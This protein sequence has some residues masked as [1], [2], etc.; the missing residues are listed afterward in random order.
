MLQLKNII[1][2]YVTGNETV[3]ALK[4]INI[5][6][7]KNEFVSILGQSGGGKTTLLN[8]IGGLDHYTKGDLIIGGKSTKEFSQRDWDSYRNHSIGF[9]FQSYNLI[10]HQSVLANVELALTLS[11]VGKAERKRRAK[12]ALEAVGLGA[13]IRKRPNQL[14]GGQMQRVAIARALVNDPEILLADEPT[15]ALD[16]ETSIQIMDILKEVAKDRLV[17]MVTHNPELATQYSTRIV[18]LKDGQIIDDNNP[19]DGVDEPEN[20]SKQKKTSMGFLTALSLSL[21]NLMT[22]RGRTILTAFA[23][24]IGI[25][26]IALILSLST[27][28]NNYITNI[29]KSTMSSYPITI[30]SQSIDMTSLFKDEHDVSETSSTH[31][32][33]AVYGNPSALQRLGAMTTS[34]TTNN[35]TAFKKY[36]DEKDSPILEYIGETGIH[37]SYD[38]SFDVYTYDSNKVLVNTDGSSFSNATMNATMMGNAMTMTASSSNGLFEE[39]LAGKG[40]SLVSDAIKE[41]YDL[42]Y[43]E[44]PS[45]YDEVVLVLNEN[46]EVST[47]D[48]YQLGYLPANEYESI[49]SQ[50][51]E[52]KEVTYDTQSIDYADICNQS[53]YM[54]P[55]SDY[56]VENT[57][58]TFDNVSAVKTSLE[59]L[60]TNALSLKIK[61]IIRLNEDADTALI[62]NTIGYTSALTDYIITQTNESAVVKAQ[63][64]QKDINVLTGISFTP[65]DENAKQQDTL[66]YLKN[67]G[68]SEKAAICKDILNTMYSSDPNTAKQIL[69][70]DEAT[71]AAS[72]D[73]YLQDPEAEVLDMIYDTYISAGSYDENMTTFGVVNLDTPS[74]IQIYADSFNDKDSITNCIKDYNKTVSED[75]QIQYTD[76]VALLMSS[77]TTIVN[78]ISY[79]L[80]AFVAV[81]L[82]VSSIM[83]GIITY[84]SVLERTKE[85]GILR[86]VG[87]SKKDISRVFNAETFIV[88]LFSGSLGVIITYLLCIPINS[89]IEKVVGDASMH[90][91]LPINSAFVLILISIILTLIAGL[92]PSRIAAKKDP[93]T[94]LRSE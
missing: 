44:W 6:F 15:G 51:Q 12:E 74:S 20:H 45:K 76:Y 82:V 89:V 16:T 43:G 8:I 58:G 69:S 65:T 83:I 38:V 71:I 53:F 52:G 19:F 80:I 46:N 10:P 88:G 35:L 86:A 11:G 85:I 67:L 72:F 60:V 30:D 79:V 39:L 23:G 55:T 48:L 78:A 41:Q 70:Q 27:G 37:Y 87:A 14:S 42:V 57:H 93:V 68:I 50:I 77:V 17:I 81:S 3:R 94:A 31:D 32:K 2:E 59:N 7:R 63:Q 18:R 91:F 13:H 5:A 40:D 1:K 26:G 90:A 49:L 66:S 61:G 47:M 56:Y 9:V 75:D 21:N 4:G 34:I 25:I 62:N 24:S 36:L 54:I 33:D 73:Q 22:K 92:F 84:I 28:V 29:Q 64:E